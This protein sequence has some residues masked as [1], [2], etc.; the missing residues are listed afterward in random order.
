MVNEP[1]KILFNHFTGNGIGAHDRSREV[2]NKQLRKVKT[3]VL[4]VSLFDSG[5]VYIF[6]KGVGK[7]TVK[8]GQVQKQN[9]S[10]NQLHNRN[11]TQIDI[12]KR[13]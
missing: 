11:N 6:V 12:A 13:S 7:T 3:K 8:M 5:D 4:R 2:Y 10:F 1:N 9:C